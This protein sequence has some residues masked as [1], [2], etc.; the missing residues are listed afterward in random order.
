MKILYLAPQPF[1][2]ARGTPIRTRNIVSGLTAAGHHVDLLCFP[3]GDPLDM[4]GLRIRRTMGIPGIRQIPVGPS[5]AKFPLNFLMML[6]MA[7]L[8]LFHDYDVIDAV[9]ESAFYAVWI[10]ALAR[11]PLVYHMDS[12]LSDHLRYSGVFKNRWLLRLAERMERATIRRSRMA[13]TVS[14]DLSRYVATVAPGVRIFQLEDAPLNETF[15]EAPERAA[16]LRADLGL[17]GHP[18]VVYT[19]NFSSYQ[20]V[21]LLVDAAARVTRERPDIRFVLV[22]GKRGDVDLLRDRAR[23]MGVEGVVRMTGSKPV[24]EIP[25][26]VTLA[27]VLISPRTLGANTPMKIYDYMQSGRPV[28]ATDLPTHTTVLDASC[29]WLAAPEPDALARAV[30]DAVERADESK[31]KA[32]AAAAR[33]TE[34]FALPVFRRRVAE[35]F[36]DLQPGTARP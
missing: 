11:K 6:K 23:R 12:H 35:A 15:T 26:Y 19:G 27:D 10:A 22:G 9:E 3:M 20:G 2:T 24:E 14:D 18:V 8:C 29:A 13:I 17:E 5:P 4:P 7:A 16:K 21:D 31:A 36:A 32:A 1:F 28:V 34:R 30:I 25:A 33:V